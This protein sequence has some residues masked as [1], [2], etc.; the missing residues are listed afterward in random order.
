MCWEFVLRRREGEIAS[1]ICRC[2]G[3]GAGEIKLE[4]LVWLFV[5]FE[6]E[7]HRQVANLFWEDCLGDFFLERRMMNDI[8]YSLRGSSAMHFCKTFV[9]ERDKTRPRITNA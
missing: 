4:S 7:L 2:H 6:I 9:Q 3:G 5:S 1:A 8:Q